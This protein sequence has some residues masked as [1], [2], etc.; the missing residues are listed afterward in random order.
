MSEPKHSSR[1]PS[2]LRVGGVRM[3]KENLVS[4]GSL[5]SS[6]LCQYLNDNRIFDEQI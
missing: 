4:R 1:Q 3:V 6:L 5:D 2:E